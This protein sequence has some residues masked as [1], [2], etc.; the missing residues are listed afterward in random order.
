MTGD[1]RGDAR[2]AILKQL[3]GQ[4]CKEQLKLSL[5][6]VESQQK[7]RQKGETEN[8]CRVGLPLEGT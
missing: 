8:S 4:G 6:R 1:S 2:C 7:S 3:R 5:L